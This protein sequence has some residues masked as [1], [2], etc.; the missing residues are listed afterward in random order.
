MTGLRLWFA[1]LMCGI[2][3]IR[4]DAAAAKYWIRKSEDWA[5]W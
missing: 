1:N 3:E 2:A 4:G 5:G